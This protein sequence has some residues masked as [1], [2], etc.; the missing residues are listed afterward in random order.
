MRG[1]AL[2]LLLFCAC[3]TELSLA[4]EVTSATAGVRADTIEVEVTCDVRVGR[5][6]LAGDD[7]ILPQAAI[8]VDGVPV[9]EVVLERPEGFDGRLEPGQSTVVETR[10]SIPLSAFPSTRDAVCGQ[11]NVEVSVQYEAAQ[12]PDDPL[13]PP[14]R[15][16]GAA[17]GEATVRCD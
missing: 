16:L 9:A 14:I 10:G 2:L 5:F 1:A 12:Q 11:S 7:F 6:A 3:D 13:D 17:Q 15:A 8:V 4:V